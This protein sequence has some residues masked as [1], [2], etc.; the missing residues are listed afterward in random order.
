LLRQTRMPLTEGRPPFESS[1]IP[2][3]L[4]NHPRYEVGK[5]LGAGGMGVVYRAVHRLMKRPVALKLIRPDLL[6]SPASVQRFRREVQAAAR[7]AHPNIV[8]A[9]DAEHVGGV[10]FLVMEF[11][12]GRTLDQIV[13]ENGPMSYDNACSLMRQVAMGLAHAHAQGMVHRDIKPQNL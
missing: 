8:T 3:E 4:Q 1:Q 2:L 13:R 12:E 11:V 9:H 7:L 10:H 6:A 5:R